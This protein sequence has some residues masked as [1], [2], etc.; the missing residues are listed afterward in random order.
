VICGCCGLNEIS[1]HAQCVESDQHDRLRQRGS[2]KENVPQ[3]PPKAVLEP[4]ELLLNH[5]TSITRVVFKQMEE[6]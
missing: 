2:F 5:Y 6:I 3:T 4:Y 1:M